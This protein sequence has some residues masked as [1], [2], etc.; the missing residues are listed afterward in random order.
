MRKVLLAITTLAVII[1]VAG[2]ATLPM[3]SNLK[4]PVSMTTIEN[5]PTRTKEFFA[6][7]RAIWLFWGLI[8]LSLPAFD[9]VIGPEIAD[10]AG[11][12]N[13]KITTQSTFIDVVVTG[14]TD[15]I[16]TMRT[17]TIE[18]QAYE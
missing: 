18:G 15:G 4:K 7:G 3:E 17:V 12:Q 16:V 6:E 10:H 11:V 2:C 1:A 5:N 9:E 13:L 14:L 8:D